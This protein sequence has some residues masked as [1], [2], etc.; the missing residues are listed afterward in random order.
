MTMTAAPGMDATVPLRSYSANERA[1][2]NLLRVGGPTPSAELARLTGLSAQSASVITRGLEAEGLVRRGDP[3]KGRVGK[4]STPIGLDPDGAFSVGLRLGRRQSDLVLMDFIGQVRGQITTRHAYPTPARTLEFVAQGL[5]G[6]AET[7]T[8]AQ[9]GRIA[10]LGV[11]M[12]YDLWDWLDLV[13]APEAE[14][15]AWKSFDPEAALSARTGLPVYVGNDSSLA[16]YGEHLFGAAAGISDFGYIYLGAFVGGGVMMDNRLYAG[17]GGNAGAIASIPVP[18]RDGKVVQLLEVA[19]VY[20]LERRIDLREAGAAKRLLGGAG[21][22]GFEDI[23][24]LWLGEV[25]EYIAYG[26]VSLV[27]ILDVPVVVIDGSVPEALRA[28]L[29]AQVRARIAGMD[30]RGIVLPEVVAG[31]LGTTACALGAAYQP[32]VA[33]YL[34]E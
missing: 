7:L 28:L 27:A 29:V 4:P 32:I 10:G 23:R 14:M 26:T 24:D 17:P 30:T 13:G 31:R 3:V 34:V 22:D 20:E 2:L 19:S 8:A 18:R 9:R 33:R 1:I 25:A 16:C 6:F 15:L 11:G 5:A 21:W 12:P